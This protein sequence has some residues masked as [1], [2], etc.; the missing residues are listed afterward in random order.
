MVSQDANDHHRQLKH[1][2]WQIDYRM[3]Q[4]FRDRIISR[5]TAKRGGR[6][7][8]DKNIREGLWCKVEQSCSMSHKIE[9][10]D[11]SEKTGAGTAPDKNVDTISPI[12]VQ[13]M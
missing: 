9:I 6:N 8:R 11:R 7:I 12:S 2:Q 4:N 13:S 5:I 1:I 3:S 10:P